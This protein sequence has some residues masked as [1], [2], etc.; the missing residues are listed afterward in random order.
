MAAYTSY[1]VWDRTRD[2]KGYY[3]V[4]NYREGDAYKRHCQKLDAKGI[5]AAREEAARIY[6]ERGG[7][8][9][10]ASDKTISAYASEYIDL[11]LKNHN[12]EPS[13]AGPYYSI[14]RQLQD[15]LGGISISDL[16]VRTAQ[17]WVSELSEHLAP[18]TVLKRA[19]FL[20][21]VCDHAVNLGELAENPMKKVQKPHRE[22][23]TRNS[24]PHANLGPLL[25]Y[26]ADGRETPTRLAIRLALTTGM[27]P[28]ELCGLRWSDV[29]L[30]A[31]TLHVARVIGKDRRGKPYLKDFPK[32]SRSYR[33]IA[34][35]D[36]L[37]TKLRERRDAMAEGC[38][39]AGDGVEFGPDLYVIGS[40]DGR[41]M[42]PTILTRQWNSV[43]DDRGIVGITG[44]APRL[45]DLRHTFATVAIASGADVKVVAD[46][47]GHDPAMTLRVYAD[48]EPEAKRALADRMDSVFS[49][50]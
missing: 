19:N 8:S 22:H 15:Q 2:K 21:E 42:S 44:K 4:L 33:W 46:S 36:S 37:A 1:R 29:D 25:E 10:R 35:S 6:I 16:D 30:D 27:R 28:G 5:K 34:I 13:T 12:I 38:A 20:S 7:S 17:G 32:N 14:A 48:A 11:R 23:R 43:A 50:E 47:M 3:V 45:Y 31:M 49:Q 39:E 26:L 40:I 24:I 41:W 18:D 9:V